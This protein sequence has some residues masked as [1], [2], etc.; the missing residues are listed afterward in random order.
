MPT[1]T[2]SKGA[3]RNHSC[4]AAAVRPQRRKQASPRQRANSNNTSADAPNGSAT[5]LMSSTARHRPDSSCGSAAPPDDTPSK[6][7][8]CDSTISKADAEVKATSTGSDSRSAM[9]PRRNRPSTA[10]IR[11]DSS[12]RPMAS[13]R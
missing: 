5:R 4:R 13:A 12:A 10:S 2:A 3:S 6:G 7:P 11:P 9:K 1:S 8:N